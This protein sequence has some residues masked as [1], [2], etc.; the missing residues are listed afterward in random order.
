MALNRR[1]SSSSRSGL[2]GKEITPTMS[3]FGRIPEIQRMTPH[4]LLC[5]NLSAKQCAVALTNCLAFRLR[6][7][8]ST[9]LDQVL[10]TRRSPAERAE[11]PRTARGRWR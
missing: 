9:N 5:E 2:R 4:A 11:A 6:D 10:G 3:S 8:T 1:T 7:A